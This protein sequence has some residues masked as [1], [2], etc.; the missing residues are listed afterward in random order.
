MGD[1]CNI[2]CNFLSS[3]DLIRLKTL[4]DSWRFE[5][6]CVARQYFTVIQSNL[7][8]GLLDDSD[9]LATTAH[10]FFRLVKDCPCEN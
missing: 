1:Q 10:H 6:G 2:E 9:V 7:V 4:H 3:H 5:G 8:R